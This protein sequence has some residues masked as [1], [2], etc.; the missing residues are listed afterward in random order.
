MLQALEDAG[1]VC[2]LAAGHESRAWALDPARFYVTGRTT[3]MHCAGSNR[4][5]VVPEQEVDLWLGVPCLDLGVQA[6]YERHTAQ[7]P[8]WFGRLYRETLIRRLIA[9]EH[10]ALLTPR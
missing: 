3:V 7:A 5:L 10:T 9:A 6:V 8:T 4:T 1:L 2:R